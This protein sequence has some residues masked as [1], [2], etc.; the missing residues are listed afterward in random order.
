MSKRYAITSLEEA[1]AY[2]T[3]T[4]LGQ[5]LEECAR[6]LTELEDTT[7]QE[8]FGPVDAMKLRSSMTLFARAAPER[9]VFQTVLER[10]FDG[11]VDAA[12]DVTLL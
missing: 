8:I 7:A 3:H 6:I 10:Y 11:R 4:I 9:Q 5:R 1:R 12:T 2:L